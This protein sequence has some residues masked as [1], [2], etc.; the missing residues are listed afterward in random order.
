MSD[1]KAVFTLRKEGRLN[2]ALA[3][4]REGYAAN[5]NDI[6][7]QHAYG[8]VLYDL[9]KHAVQEFEDKQIPPG[10]LANLLNT[11]LR[12]Y[13]QFGANERPGMLHSNLLQQVVKASSV[14]P[15]FL[16]FARWW[17]PE[18]F[19]EEDRKPFRPPDG[20]REV[21]SLATRY[22]YAVGR[23]AAR[24]AADIPADL[25]AWAEQQVDAALH[26]S[27]NDQW[28]H[29][30]K[31]KF[32][33]TRGE[34]EQARANLLPV[35]R[36]QS[37]AAWVWSLLGTTY[38]TE[39]PAKAVICYFRAVH[40]A[41][42]PQE[43]ANTHISLARLL[44]Q[45]QRFPEAAVQVRAALAYRQDNNF[46]VPQALEQLA[47]TDWYRELSKRTDLPRP[48]DMAEAAEAILFE[49]E[50]ARMTY[51]VGVLDHHNSDKALAHVAFSLED[52][53]V[54]PYRRFKD[55]R[56]IPIGRIVEVGFLDEARQ[57]QRWRTTEHTS[58]D[59]F[60]K[61]M[62]GEMSKREDQSFGFLKTGT[63]ERVFVHPALMER[64]PHADSKGLTC[65]AV[66][67]RDKQGK[68]GWRAL[69]WLD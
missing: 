15:A 68:P 66:M 60:V 45:Q 53:V 38:E 30:Y 20:G 29:Y 37:R 44:A 26:D 50:Q 10:R 25:L 27:P 48:P 52:G 40:V 17:G 9:I 16:K 59:G 3:M 6:W 11:W 43:V 1:S 24:Q 57:P 67:S 61:P 36:R 18:Y 39:D 56:D 28:L 13:H 7:M 69:S 12:E 49:G 34:S 46:R 62:T 65:L 41:R 23:E 8:W 31:S 35:I 54:L 22:V 14:W 4:A 63:G 5:A 21:P 58:I 33:L 51:R 47:G 64:L 55:I 2:E 42:Q 32:L 19:T